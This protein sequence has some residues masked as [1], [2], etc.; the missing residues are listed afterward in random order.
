M[1]LTFLWIVGVCIL[2]TGGWQVCRLWRRKQCGQWEKQKEQE[3][4]EKKEDIFS[5]TEQ[6]KWLRQLLQQREEIAMLQYRQSCGAWF[7][8]ISSGIQD[9]LAQANRPCS[10]DRVFCRRLEVCAE[11]ESLRSKMEWRPAM[12]KPEPVSAQEQAADAEQLQEMIRVEKSKCHSPA[13]ELP[14]EDLMNAVHPCL[15]ALLQAA[16]EGR[17]E[18]CRGTLTELQDILSRWGIR[19]VWYSGQLVQ[20]HP[21]MKKNYVIAKSYPVPALFYCEGEEMLRIGGPGYTGTVKK[22]GKNI[23]G[24]N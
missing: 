11:N 2:C 9:L 8:E 7:E 6:Q 18:V 3:K 20:Q 16:G 21:S 24:Q 14:W 4:Q 12:Q 23:D 22:G 15:E 13:V 10:Q 19:A 1:K 17:A 5:Q